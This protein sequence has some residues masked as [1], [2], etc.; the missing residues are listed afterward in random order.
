MQKSWI[1]RSKADPTKTYTVQKIT[2]WQWECT[3]PDFT[4]RHHECKHIKGIQKVYEKINQQNQKHQPVGAESRPTPLQSDDRGHG[5]QGSNLPSGEL[6]GSSSNN[7]NAARISEGTK[8]TGN[9]GHS[10]SSQAPKSSMGTPNA[11][12]SVSGPAKGSSQTTTGQ[13]QGLCDENKK[14]EQFRAKR[15]SQIKQ[16]ES[17]KLRRTNFSKDLYDRWQQLE[18]KKI[19]K[20]DEAATID[21]QIKPLLIGIRM[22]NK[23]VYEKPPFDISLVEISD[24]A[25]ADEMID[26]VQALF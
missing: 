7:G 3:C 17:W 6:R 1:I 16:Y 18:K 8:P 4:M 12:P 13:N 24:E 21:M 14:R 19:T 11:S 26:G 25:V 23:N 9:P 15:I 5:Q 20:P 10:S 2:D 22:A